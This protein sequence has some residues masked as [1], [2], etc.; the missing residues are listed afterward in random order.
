LRASFYDVVATLAAT[1]LGASPADPFQHRKMFDFRTAHMAVH[2]NSSSKP[3]AA[4]FTGRRC[5]RQFA[6]DQERRVSARTM[7]R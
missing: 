2:K 1:S 5:A 7:R 4:G 6:F 3:P